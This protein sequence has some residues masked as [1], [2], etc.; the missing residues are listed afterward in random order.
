[1]R[2]SSALVAAILLAACVAPSGSPAETCDGTWRGIDS[3]VAIP[4]D[5]EAQPVPATCI[6]QVGDKRIR[7]GFSMPPGPTC[8]LLDAVE[9]V[10]SADAVSVR[11]MVRTD[12]DPASGACAD[13]P[14]RVATEV[15]LQAPVADRRLLDGSR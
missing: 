2:A 1:M 9:V 6:R 12:D 7:I 14:G 11:L 8:Y 10:E 5:A 15:D 3:V 13:R 4:D